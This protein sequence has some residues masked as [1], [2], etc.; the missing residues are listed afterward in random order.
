MILGAGIG[1]V[2]SISFLILFGYGVS[3]V[4]A[5]RNGIDLTYFLFPLFGILSV[6]WST[7][8]WGMLITGFAVVLNCAAYVAAG[9]VVRVGLR[10]LR[11]MSQEFSDMPLRHK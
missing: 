11:K 5:L 6:T 10:V 2:A 1:L 4:L 8:P 9:L 3:G 7:T